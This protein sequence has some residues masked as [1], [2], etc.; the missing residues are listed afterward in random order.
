MGI[1]KWEFPSKGTRLFWRLKYRFL[2]VSDFTSVPQYLRSMQEVEPQHL[3]KFH[4]NR[5]MFKKVVN[6][7]LKYTENSHG[8]QALIYLSSLFQLL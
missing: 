3:A 4:R 1:H 6:K 7:F 8:N 5:P 2:E